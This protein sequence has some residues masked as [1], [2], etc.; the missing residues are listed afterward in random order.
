MPEFKLK[1][2]TF[3][4]YAEY[5]DSGIDWLGEIPIKY[6]IKRLKYLFENHFGGV[7]GDEE[8]NDKNDMICLRVAD[9]DFNKLKISDSNLTIRNIPENQKNRILNSRS[10]LLE[11][12]G[13]GENQLVGRAVKNT[14]RDRSVCSNFIELMVTS[15]EQDPRYITYLMASLYFSNIN[16]RSIKQTTGIQNLDTYQYLNEIVPFIPLIEQNK[17]SDFL[18]KETDKID[19]L[20][21]QKQ[22]LI[23]LLKEKRT[24]LIS[25]AVTKGLDLKVK[26][27][28]SGI[29][30]LGQIPEHWEIKRLKYI[31]ESIIGLTYSPDDI[32]DDENS[33]ILVLRSSNIQNDNLMLND[34]VYVKKEIPERLMV[35]EGDILICARNGSKAL[36]GKN[37][38]LHKEIKGATFGAFMAVFRSDCWNFLSYFFKSGLFMSQLSST[39]TATVNQ[40]TN[41]YLDNITIALPSKE[42]QSEIIL[43]L[44]KEIDR[45]NKAEMLIKKQI[46]RIKEYRTA[47]ISAAVIGKIKID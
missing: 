15:E 7:W 3:L 46:E 14:I 1:P 20:V 21:E 23:E 36:I 9:F 39:L 25:Q 35:K 45:F 16:Y 40:L 41:Y 6:E 27:K 2:R 22:K 11:K 28:D 13:G 29:P 12:S 33:G 8:K 34:N 44:K 26:M 18:D 32:V 31:G 38:C 5:K 30:W 19:R 42:E 4:K 37:V 43:Y 47:L 10:I 24:T 17:I